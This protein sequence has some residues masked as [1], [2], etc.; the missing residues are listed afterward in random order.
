MNERQVLLNRV[1][2]LGFCMHEAALFLNSDP[3]NKD[4]LAYFAKNRDL[5][6]V[7][8][9]EYVRRFG[10]LQPGDYDGGPRWKWVDGPWPWEYE[11]A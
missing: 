2:V 4:A 7:A 3:E 8:S 10:P 5:F 9:D 11:E 6:E 1:Q